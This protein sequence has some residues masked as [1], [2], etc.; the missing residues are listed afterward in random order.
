MKQ[1]FGKEIRDIQKTQTQ[2]K[3]D[4]QEFSGKNNRQYD[5]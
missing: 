4:F 3:I 5:Y 1:I 2:T